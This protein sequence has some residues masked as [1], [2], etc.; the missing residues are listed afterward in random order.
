MIG[1]LYDNR[2]IA[3]AVASWPSSIASA[4]GKEVVDVAGV[5]S[6]GGDSDECA[7]SRSMGCVVRSGCSLLKKEGRWICGVE[8]VETVVNS[9]I[10]IEG[11][12]LQ[13][14]RRKDAEATDQKHRRVALLSKSTR[15]E[16][17]R[18]EGKN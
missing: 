5:L 15:R 10:G 17:R 14:C 6:D 16:R 12:V 18:G 3:L 7:P 11:E 8:E 1:F 2:R 4:S 13:L 9:G